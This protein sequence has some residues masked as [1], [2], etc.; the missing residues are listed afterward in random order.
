MNKPNTNL[1]GFFDKMA[2]VFQSNTK[3]A[4]KASESRSKA[5]R[6]VKGTQQR[7]KQGRG[8]GG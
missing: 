4:T 6:G 8:V 3:K 2:K 7:K 5:G 1:D